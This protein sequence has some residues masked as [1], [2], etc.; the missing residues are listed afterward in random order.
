MRERERGAI[1]RAAE[2]ELRRKTDA[3]IISRATRERSAIESNRA[4]L[5]Q[6]LLGIAE[7]RS[8]R[9]AGRRS[10]SRGPGRTGRN[11][12]GGAESEPNYRSL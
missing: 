3:N 5:G 9:V 2:N 4:D 10:G 6:L 12:G 7:D 1:R 11:L 8:R